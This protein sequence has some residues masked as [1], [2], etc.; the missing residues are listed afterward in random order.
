MQLRVIALLAQTNTHSMGDSCS[1]ADVGYCSCYPCRCRSLLELL[2]VSMSVG[3]I[4]G[5]VAYATVPK[6]ASSNSRRIMAAFPA[7]ATLL[8][9]NYYAPYVDNPIYFTA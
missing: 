2:H 9:L 3:V 8:L 5:A 6:H 1:A 4:T 7:A